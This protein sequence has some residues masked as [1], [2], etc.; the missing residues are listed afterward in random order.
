MLAAHSSFRD[1]SA[2]QRN[3]SERTGLLFMMRDVTDIWGSR[4]PYQGQWPIRAD[5]RVCSPPEEW[6]QS[7][8]VLCSVGCGVDI[9]VAG[10]K[11]VGIRGR[12]GDRA[13]LGRL[14]PKGLH[15]WEANAHVDRLKRPLVRM[16]GRLEETSWEEAMRLLVAS[17]RA[18]K[19]EFGPGAI[20]IYNSGQLLLEEYYTL[21]LLADC[22]LQTPHVDGSTRLCTSTAAV[23]LIESFGTDGNPGS[24]TD[25]DTT[26]AFFIFGHNMAE[27]QTVLW[28]R[29]LDRLAGPN[30]PR[31][32]VVDPRHTATAREA[33]VHL[34]TRAGSNLP[35]M[36]GLLH[37]VVKNGQLANEFI[38]QHTVGFASLQA[39]VEQW[40]PRRTAEA[41][42]L[43]QAQLEAAADILGHTP[44]LVS[45]VLQG[46]YQSYEATATA[47][48]VN[49]LHLI[50]GLIGKP[51]ATVF[52]MNGQPSAQ[53]TREC[54]ANG[55]MVAFRNW[56]NPAHVAEQARIWKVKSEHIPHATPPTP[57]LQIFRYAE[58]GSIR[59]LWIIGTNPAVTLPSLR[60]IRG[61]LGD[62]KLF[63]I[64]Q[65]PF[66][67]E[68]G[69]L[70]DLVLPSAMWGE[71][72]GC[73]TNP[74]R[75]VHLCRQAV[76]PP[77][78][79]RSDF[80][81]FVDYARRMDFRD[82][83]GA[84]LIKWAK[85]EEA[86]IAWGECSKGRPCDYS[87]L[88]YAKL[89][90]GSGVQWPCNEKFPNGTERLY[91]DGV[92]NTAGDYCELYG[93]DL[94]TGAPISPQQYRA[95][96]PGGR[97]LIKAAEHIPPPEDTD[98][99]YPFILTTGR[100]VYHWHTRTKTG[101]VP[102]LQTAAPHSFVQ[103]SS[104]DA[105]ELGIATG[106][107]LR[108][109]SRRSV[110]TLPARI[111]DIAP[112]HVFVPFHYGNWDCPEEERAANELTNTG[113]D[114]VSKQPFLKFAAVSLAKT[115]A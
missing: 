7:T 37:L 30:R 90:A 51:G 66:L 20:G 106:D 44:T 95:A 43:A 42:G 115:T 75:T 82:R 102:A 40:T 79:A 13:N 10:G 73:I 18:I 47:V 89:S 38:E 17:S 105:K 55:E 96:D 16:N 86:F 110:I 71:K 92:F 97:A 64:V 11:M 67:S 15:G 34:A 101:R 83:E 31:L 50:R 3:R 60:R 36:L 84:P 35:L 22:G 108:I 99:E 29:V 91:G 74:E 111:G 103:V 26:D 19:T 94:V 52:Q 12:T 2:R 56:N 1:G 28:A 63:V 85:P 109:K 49:N 72:T 9:G 46:V 81:I 61:I 107:K 98:A 39:A 27:T 59:M 70:A 80:D 6:V 41:T 33:D 57:A 68:T 54:G 62:E 113:W 112:G 23:A 32:V 93:H 58:K 76:Q 65:E 8:C 24:F 87:G 53:N 114:P 48:Q 21:T 104:A 14:G 78:E 5:E 69:N 77:G 45:T 100:V 88:S 4:Q 25:F